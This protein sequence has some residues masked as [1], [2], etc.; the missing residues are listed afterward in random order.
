VRRRRRAVGHAASHGRRLSPP[1]T[2][3]RRPFPRSHG[4][5]ARSW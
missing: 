3:Q 5:D 2:E 1:T 4:R